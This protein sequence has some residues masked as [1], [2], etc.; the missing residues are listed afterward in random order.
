MELS[1]AREKKITPRP[2]EKPRSPRLSLGSFVIA[3]LASPW[4]VGPQL[5]FG[6]AQQAG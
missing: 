1:F 4:D 5:G 2:Q 6:R 3:H